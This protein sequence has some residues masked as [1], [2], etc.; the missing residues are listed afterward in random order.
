LKAVGRYGELKVIEE[1]V[2]E[3]TAKKRELESRIKEL[4]AQVQELRGLIDELR[5]TA[6]GCSSLS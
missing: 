3:L 1:D 2:E 6:R 5:R 4:S